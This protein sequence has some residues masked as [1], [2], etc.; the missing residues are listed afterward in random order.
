M[1]AKKGTRPPNA[2]KGRKKGTPNKL[3]RDVREAIAAFAEAN[4]GRLQH[5][6]DAI[7][8]NDP[9]KAA[10]L[11]TRLLEYHVPKLARAEV[12]HSG[13]AAR[14]RYEYSTAELETMLFDSRNKYS[15]AELEAML[16]ENR[17][18][19]RST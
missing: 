18:K 2:G 4:V 19:D 14:S 1:A 12:E 9:A 8:A 11:F 16:F 15:T 6:L 13:S 17:N 3:T 5:W 7:A 10:D